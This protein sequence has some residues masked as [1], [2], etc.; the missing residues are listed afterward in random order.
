MNY[1]TSDLYLAGYLM[2]SGVPLKS[3]ERE[4]GTTVFCFEQTDKLLQLVEKYFNMKAI[5][6]PQQYGAA[7]KILKNILY[8][9]NYNDNYDYQQSRKGN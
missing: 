5:I 3:N 4:S 1:N 6:N 8:Q 9:K 7:L 2:A